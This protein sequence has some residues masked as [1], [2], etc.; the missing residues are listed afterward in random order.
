MSN[1]ATAGQGISSYYA[2]GGDVA[3]IKTTRDFEPGTLVKSSQVDEIQAF[4]YCL[5]D[6]INDQ[7][8]LDRML[9]VIPDEHREAIVAL[10][11]SN[12][13]DFEADEPL[14]G[15]IYSHIDGMTAD[16]DSERSEGAF[17][18]AQ[19]FSDREAALASARVVT[20][21]FG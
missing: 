15:V 3:F 5:E 9:A 14:Y 18:G 20:A 16:L 21:V 17:F 12:V 2:Y 10:A 13:G 6:G 11:T 1:S 4:L 7:T 8:F 19:R